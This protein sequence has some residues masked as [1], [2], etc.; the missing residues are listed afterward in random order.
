M[1]GLEVAA[2]VSETY[3]TWALAL[4][5][6]ILAAVVSTTHHSPKRPIYRLCYLLLIPGLFL[7]AL[8]VYYGDLVQRSL[9]AAHFAPEAALQD[10]ARN[11]NK[12]TDRQL[13]SLMSALGVIS[14]WLALYMLWWV[15]A[16]RAEESAEKKG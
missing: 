4:G 11:V 3:I 14:V 15:L 9:V 10:I 5:G 12:Y 1:T 6:G 7:L 8:S 2:S 16:R 13:T